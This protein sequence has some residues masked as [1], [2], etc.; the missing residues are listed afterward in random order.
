[1]KI[2]KRAYKKDTYEFDGWIN[3]KD[4]ATEFNPAR[5]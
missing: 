3:P 1:L 2:K 5:S 4:K